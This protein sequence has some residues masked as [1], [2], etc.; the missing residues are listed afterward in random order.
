MGIAGVV[1][2][3]LFSAFALAAFPAAAEDIPDSRDHP[4]VGRYEGAEIV[5]YKSSDFD[6]AALLRAP[7]DYNALLERN[8]TRDRSGED[9]LKL[10]G[11]V[12]EIRYQGPQGRSSLEVMRNFEKALA[13]EGFSTLFSCADGDCLSGTL[14]DNYLLGEQLD[15]TNGVSTAYF[16]KARYELS[17]LERPEGA[18]YVAILVGEYQSEL[19]TFVKVVETKEMEGDKIVVPTAEEMGA[20]IVSAGHVD[21]YGILFD[22]DEDTLRP[23]SE[24]T[25]DEIAELLEDRPD[26]KLDIVG[27]TDNQG[28]AEYNLD[29]SQRRAA[30]VVEALVDDYDIDADRLTASGAGLTQPVA[31]N[32]TEEGRAKNRRVELVAK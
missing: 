5:Y 14:R 12:T 22:L 21:I 9:W 28:T 29:L 20:A 10:E 6:E 27:H 32:D 3:I 13:G 23:E 18:V 1:R 25:L 30:S 7:H 11:R 16:D 26:M 31:S 15:P 17:E 4:L 24:P 19:T 2:R 8:A